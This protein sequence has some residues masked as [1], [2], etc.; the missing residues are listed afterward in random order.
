MFDDEARLSALF[1]VLP[2]SLV[3]VEPGGAFS[4]A[5]PGP[6]FTPGANLAE[7]IAGIHIDDR[8]KIQA[9]VEKCLA[10]PGSYEESFRTP[11]GGA[12]WLWQECSAASQLGPDG[13]RR[14]LLLCR[15]VSSR[16]AAEDVLR[17]EEEL[18]RELA[19]NATDLIIE[20]D[21][22][23]RILYISP[24][25]TKLVGRAPE[26]IIG[27]AISVFQGSFDSGEMSTTPEAEP[28]VFE[29]LQETLALGGT[30]NF[31]RYRFHH[32]DGGE[33]WFEMRARSF[34]RSDGAIRVV[35]I[36]RDVTE[37]IRAEAG[38]KKSEER[39]R[40][41]STISK[42]V[43]S[44]VLPDGTLGYVSPT[45]EEV[46]GYSPE[47]LVGT[48]PLGLVHPDDAEINRNLITGIS[49]PGER[50]VVFPPFR[51]RHA[52]GS[53]RWYEGTGLTYELV[54]GSMRMLIVSRDIT[55]RR[56]QE[57]RGAKL[58]EQVRQ[59]QKLEG[60]GVMAGGIA[61][62]F[63][64]FLTPILGEAGLALDDLP[65]GSAIRP[66]LEKIQAAARRAALLT[67]QMLAYAGKKTLAMS[68]IDLSKLVSE[69]AQLMSSGISKKVYVDQTLPEGLPLIE[70][71][72]AQLTQ[73]VM[74][75]ITNAA[76][77]VGDQEGAIAIR[78]GVT[79]PDQLDPRKLVLLE[80]ELPE[81]SY[82]Y[83]EV[84]D[85]GVGMS[86]ATQA[87]IFDP[88]F[89]TKFAGRGLGLAAVVG[90]VR[91]HRGA[92]EID[93]QAG[94]GT[95]FRVVFPA[96]TPAAEKPAASAKGNEGWKSDATVLVVDDEESVVE[97]ARETL[98]R[99]GLNVVTAADGREGV[100]VFAAN[101]DSI[102]LVVLDRTMPGLSGEEVAA[103]LKRIRPDVRIVLASGYSAERSG[104]EKIGIAHFLQKPFL[105]EDL[106][107]KVRDALA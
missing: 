78:T 50:T 25:A 81:G 57:E 47:A 28:G 79:Q 94:R 63:N 1:D 88:F 41:V 86:R 20:V 38:L 15:D 9:L 8:P 46:T 83:V 17:E 39:Y 34:T 22:T 91:G 99:C 60:L 27:N 68:S 90:I 42:D 32:P 33:R 19:E 101:S 67:S 37:R 100:A 45:C 36:S 4:F 49:E 62:D 2:E 66:R 76:E 51:S 11:G 26:E 75:L 93:S 7:L 69:M 3:V 73:V 43:I 102:D 16:I 40:I 61:H 31:L 18:Y 13:T 92:I 23:G 30:G 77:A 82:V 12:A 97:L 52:D 54:P 29:A 5:S 10:S 24:N 70:G 95:R 58:E 107:A 87:R 48:D 84:R 104:A 80:G 72:P 105:P 103:E 59:A 89:T 35:V 71:D 85:T 74:N 6:G 56:D 21:D 14:A 98:I 64:N 55:P 96:L 53:W 106:V 65:E 44:E